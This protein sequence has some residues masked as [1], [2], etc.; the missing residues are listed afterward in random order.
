MDVKKLTGEQLAEIIASEYEKLIQ[1]Q[2]N[3]RVLHEEL[4]SR[5]RKTDDTPRVE[6]PIKTDTPTA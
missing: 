3:L 6:E 5:K 2:A 4:R 1:T